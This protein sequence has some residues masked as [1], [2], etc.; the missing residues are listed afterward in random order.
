MKRHSHDLNTHLDDQIL[1][2]I[3]P[4]YD[5]ALFL[6]YKWYKNLRSLFLVSGTSFIHAGAVRGSLGVYHER[7]LHIVSFP[8]IVHPY[9]NFY[10][11]WNFLLCIFLVFSLI[12]EPYLLAFDLP[13]FS[14][15]SNIAVSFIIS[16]FLLFDTFLAF[17][18]GHKDPVTTK[19][20]LDPVGNVKDN[21]NAQNNVIYSILISTIFIKYT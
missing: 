4:Q 16:L 21:I 7:F 12:Y 20:I 17:R 1:N 11:L 6:P 13:K 10:W 9:S 5:E 15:S 2:Q 14:E 8:F 18:V 19:V 3:Q